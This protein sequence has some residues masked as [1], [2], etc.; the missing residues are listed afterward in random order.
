MSKKNPSTVSN[1]TSVRV[2]A[3]ILTAMGALLA[4]GACSSGADTSAADVTKIA[5]KKPKKT[6]PAG[7]RATADMVAAASTAK[8]GPV[9]L[10][11]DLRDR[12]EV[13]QPLDVD[14]ALVPAQPNIDRVQVKFQAEDG[15]E[16]VS[17]GDVEP[18]EK[19]ADGVPIRRTV[20]VVPHRDGIFALSAVVSTDSANSSGSRTFS[21]PVIAGRGLS[22][23]SGGK[24]E[25]AAGPSS[26]GADRR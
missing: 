20:R 8:T 17:G 19:P 15:L 7:E 25:V 3:G 21:I 2:A 9:E 23:S 14:V 10:K 26:P 1:R 12:P 18:I 5:L 4:L 22:D 11:F 24:E 16:L 13:G 6:T